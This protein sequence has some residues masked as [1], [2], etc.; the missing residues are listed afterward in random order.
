MTLLSPC[1]GHAMVQLRV[2]A[3]LMP[4]GSRMPWRRRQ[5]ESDLALM[6]MKVVR[7]G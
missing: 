4:R 5:P 3:R 6:V 7:A 1:S 2:S